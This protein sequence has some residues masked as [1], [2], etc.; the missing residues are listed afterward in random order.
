MLQ[1]NFTAPAWFML[2]LAIFS[3]G[4]AIFALRSVRIYAPNFQM[5][6]LFKSRFFFL[7]AIALLEACMYWMV[8]KRNIYRKASWTH[9]WLYATAYS[10]PFVKE[11]LFLFYTKFA[12]MSEMRYSI[13]VFTMVQLC[14][15][16][17]LM[18]LAHIF[19]ARLLIRIFSKRPAV[20][21]A[22]AEPVNMLD[23]IL[24]WGWRIFERS[25]RDCRMINSILWICRLSVKWL[26]KKSF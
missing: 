18:V 7:P 10:T 1:R 2:F 21:Q 3:A 17:G 19:F 20:Q 16:W 14:I 11:F 12:A 23:D 6:L 4:L 22:A 13:R 24:D 8:R 5:T 15:F 26:I 9:I 25:R